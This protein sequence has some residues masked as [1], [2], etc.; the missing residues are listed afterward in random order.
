MSS[1]EKVSNVLGDRKYEV[2]RTPLS[3][4]KSSTKVVE[5]CTDKLAHI[6]LMEKKYLTK[7]VDKGTDELAYMKQAVSKIRRK[8]LDQF[9]G[10]SSGFKGRFKLDIG[11]LKTTFSKSHPELYK[12]LF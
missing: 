6:L 1:N 2:V 5:K 3:E 10:K 12:E 11:F 7:D 4:K 8:G 9:E